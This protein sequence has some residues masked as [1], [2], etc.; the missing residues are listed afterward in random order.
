MS[1]NNNEN[2][3]AKQAPPPARVT[4]KTKKVAVEMLALIDALPASPE[5]DAL[6]L[7]GQIAEW[8]Y[9]KDQCQ[10][11]LYTHKLTESE[12]VAGETIN[13]I[14]GEIIKLTKKGTWCND[15]GCSAQEFKRH[16][17]SKK[18]VMA[19]QKRKAHL[20]GIRAAATR[21]INAGV[22]ATTPALWEEAWGSVIN[23][24]YNMS[25]NYKAWLPFLPSSLIHNHGAE[26]G[27]SSSDEEE[28]SPRPQ[29]PRPP[30]PPPPPP[31]QDLIANLM[32]VHGDEAPP[33]LATPC[34]AGGEGGGAPAI[35]AEIVE[36]AV[37]VEP[38]KTAPAATA[39]I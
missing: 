31:P 6:L 22:W 3:K 32:A 25:D 39:I 13:P 24:I 19:Q 7:H 21:R 20:T 38:A 2:K 23:E 10:V 34:P 11:Q 36:E 4:A 35:I 18:C 15:C 29:P 37:V 14:T 30:S 28:F 9:H 33:V 12:K 8:E 5:K 17:K 1:N 16:R 27:N 26:D